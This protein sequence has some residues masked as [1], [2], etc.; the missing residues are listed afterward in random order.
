MVG[1]HCNC[2]GNS[3]I[4]LWERRLESDG[5]DRANLSSKQT[6]VCNAII[7]GDAANGHADPKVHDESKVLL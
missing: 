4:R 6:E 5:D 7:P 3:D 1:H 2:N